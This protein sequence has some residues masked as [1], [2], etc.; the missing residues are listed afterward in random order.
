MSPSLHEAQQGFAEALT[1]PTA[2]VPTAL[3]RCPSVADTR[4]FAVYRNNVAV[5]LIAALWDSFPVT[6]RL[7][8]DD[9]FQ[10][11]ARAYWPLHLPTSPMLSRWGDNFPDF[12]AAFAPARTVP[13]LADIARLEAAWNRSYHSREAAPLDLSILCRLTPEE[14]GEAVLHF[15]P[16]TRLVCS[17]YPIA[18]IWAA[19]QRETVEPIAHWRPEDVLIVRPTS[20]VLLYCL[21]TGASRFVMSLLRGKTISKAAEYALTSNRGFDLNASLVGLLQA[22]AI[23]GL[24]PTPA[25]KAIS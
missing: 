23:I 7:V 6:A 22:G 5:G 25:C 18:A 16:S 14:F 10:S 1:D 20:D 2:P 3:A 17:E 11:M 9:F 19:H 15:H 13:Y 8:G 21:P 24:E 12:I 4:R